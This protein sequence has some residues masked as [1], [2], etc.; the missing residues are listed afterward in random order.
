MGKCKFWFIF[1][2]HIL[3]HQHAPYNFII[4]MR[5]AEHTAIQNTHTFFISTYL[6]VQGYGGN[7]TRADTPLSTNKN[8]VN[9]SLIAVYFIVSLSMFHIH[10][11][12]LLLYTSEWGDRTAEKKRTERRIIKI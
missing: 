10:F 12:T 3:F 1:I 8:P 11:R 2:W 9:L 6:I 4:Y 7:E 5:V